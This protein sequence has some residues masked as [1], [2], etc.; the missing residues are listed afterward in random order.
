MREL[1]TGRQSFHSDESQ[2]DTVR[3]P[4]AAAD[5]A[6]SDGGERRLQHGRR[7]SPAHRRTSSAVS[8][9]VGKS[10][11]AGTACLPAG[12]AFSSAGTAGLSRV[13]AGT[14][15]PVAMLP[16]L[17]SGGKQSSARQGVLGSV[18][19]LRGSF[20]ADLDPASRREADGQTD[21]HRAATEAE[22]LSIPVDT[23]NAVGSAITN[24][25]APRGTASA[26]GASWQQQHMNPGPLTSE[27]ELLSN[28]S[29]IAVRNSL[30]CNPKP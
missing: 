8:Q 28:G 26:A 27:I 17:Q 25:K 22:D 30:I 15:A 7:Y 18:K 23:L 9:L 29:H 24:D 1:T 21:R 19:Q 3:Q 12:I 16:L 2:R 10:M 13:P 6:Q 5:T 20:S 14:P 11:P 4:A